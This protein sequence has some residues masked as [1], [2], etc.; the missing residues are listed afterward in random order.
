MIIKATQEQP[1]FYNQRQ[2]S[3][4]DFWL[5]NQL[6]WKVICSL[7]FIIKRQAAYVG[8]RERGVVT[9]KV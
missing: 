6:N 2:W 7:L 5:C 8:K 9:A 4:N 3:V 1:H